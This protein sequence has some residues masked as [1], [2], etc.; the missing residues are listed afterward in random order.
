MASRLPTERLRI[1]RQE[2]PSSSLIDC[3]S[4]PVR[5]SLSSCLVFRSS[6][7]APSDS[8]SNSRL[9][10]FNFVQAARFRSWRLLAPVLDSASHLKS[11][12]MCLPFIIAHLHGSGKM[13]TQSKAVA[14]H[15]VVPSWTPLTGGSYGS[16]RKTHR[17]DRTMK[18]SGV[19][20]RPTPLSTL[21]ISA[22]LKTRE[23]KGVGGPYGVPCQED[24]R[25][26]PTRGGTD[27]VI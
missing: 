25:H 8:S 5:S 22:I 10:I 11:R 19:N 14:I 18:R 24:V 17:S 9:R 15:R 7:R 2:W 1:S 26:L 20:E 13:I 16:T 21:C 12:Y 3:D 27:E 6:S 4:P 23:R